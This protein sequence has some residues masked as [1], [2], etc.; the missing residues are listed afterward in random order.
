MGAVPSGRYCSNLEQ[1]LPEGTAPIWSTTFWKVLLQSGAL[2]SGRY[3]SNLEHYLLEGT[4]PDWSSTVSKV[5]QH[6]ENCNAL[7]FSRYIWGWGRRYTDMQPMRPRVAENLNICRHFL[8]KCMKMIAFN[9]LGPIFK[10]L[11][12][13]IKCFCQF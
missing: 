1:Y 12:D 9:K 6:L 3:C 7:Q 5:T 2:P 11:Y 4:A 8:H 10:Y 13:K